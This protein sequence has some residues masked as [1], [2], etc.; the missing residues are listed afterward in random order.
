MGI[1]VKDK[2]FPSSTGI[3][4]VRY[5]IWAPEEP[6]A[7]AQIIHGM[8]EHIERYHDFATFLAENNILVFGMDLPGHGKSIAD[9]QPKGYFGDQNGWDHLI[10]DNK[11]MHDLVLADYPSVARI[12][13]GHSMGSFLARTYAGRMGVDFDAFVFSGTAGANP[14]LPVAKMIAKSAI[15]KGKGKQPNEQLNALSFAAYNK[16]F[17]PARTECDWLS[18]DTANVD[19]YVA[20][21]LCGFVFTSNAF[22]DLFTGLQEVSNLNWAKRVP[23]RPIFLMSGSNDPVGNMG[24][25]VKQVEKWLLKSGHNVTTKLYPE[26]RHEMLNETNRSEV[27]NDVLLFIETVC[28]SGE[29]Q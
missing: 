2:R 24:K 7:C 22:F 19:R 27:Y 6:H 3:C 8:A 14:A 4:D 28:A 11:T 12:L 10:Q 5:R 23:N 13:F 25:G 16:K 29:L 9:G 20:D 21:P 1:V 18:R 15:K 17:K 26:G